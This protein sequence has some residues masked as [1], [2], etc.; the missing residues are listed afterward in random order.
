MMTLIDLNLILTII[1][2]HKIAIEETKENKVYYDPSKY[3]ETKIDSTK[4]EKE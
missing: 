1:S 2:P 3:P 4:L